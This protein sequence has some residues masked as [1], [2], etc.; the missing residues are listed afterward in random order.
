MTTFKDI[1]SAFEAKFAIDENLKFKARVRCNRLV[2]EWAAKKLG[3]AGLQAG[4][5]ANEVTM[6]DLEKP[7]ADA[8]FRRIRADFDAK[9]VA[10]SDHQIRRTLDD[11]LAQALAELKDGH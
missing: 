6:L 1:K 4:A 3:L 9:G 8:V 10:Q 5:Y 7:G 2:G 11:N